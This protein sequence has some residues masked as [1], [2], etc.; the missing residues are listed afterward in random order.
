MKI[1]A[2]VILLVFGLAACSHQPVSHRYV[3]D[4]AKVQK[5]ERSARLSSHTVDIIWVNPP[6]K[7]TQP[8]KN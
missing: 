2:L 7:R 1:Y 6:T 3:I 5:V 8:S 4:T